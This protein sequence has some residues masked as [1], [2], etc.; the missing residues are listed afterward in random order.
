MV[1]GG[2]GANVGITLFVIAEGRYEPQNFPVVKIDDTKLVWDYGTDSSNYQ[3]LSLSL[4]GLNGG[5]TFLTEYSD[6][7]S[8]TANPSYA[9]NLATLYYNQCG[10][11]FGTGGTQ[12]D[13]GVTAQDDAGVSTQD[14]PDGGADASYNA[15][16]SYSADADTDAAI[17]PDASTDDAGVDQGFDA[18]APDPQGTVGACDSFDDL[19]LATEGMDPS[20]VTL[21]RLRAF[22]PAS[23]L[24][25]DLT[26][27]ASA[28]Q[29]P[30]SNE[31][32][33]LATGSSNQAS[34]T[35]FQTKNVGTWILV[36]GTV[37]TI[38]RTLRRKKKRNAS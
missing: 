14:T 22:L 32:T 15:D 26:L 19:K 36:G 6:R 3:A 7:Q 38:A 27:Q 16:A 10:S 17:D 37:L 18:S 8:P 23:A 5:R 4:M 20:F 29:Q 30:V 28:S 25:Q 9:P 2:V 24:A 35:P 12:N 33:A 13:A 1:A 31:H 21:T 11:D 34:V